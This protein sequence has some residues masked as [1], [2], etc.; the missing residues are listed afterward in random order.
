LRIAGL[1]RDS[2][3]PFGVEL[4]DLHLDVHAGEIVGI[5]GVSGNGQKELLQVLSGEEPL[6]E[7]FP[8]QIGG[9]EA[10]R[11]GPRARRRLGQGFCPAA[12]CRSSSWGAKSCRRRSC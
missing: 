12:T 11:L 1:S 5:A 8:L 3:D 4:K 7:R 2:D 9:I 6:A 10:G